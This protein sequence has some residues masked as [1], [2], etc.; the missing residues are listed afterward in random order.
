MENKNFPGSF[1]CKRCNKNKDNFF[2]Q[3]KKVTFKRKN[4]NNRK[5]FKPRKGM[6][7]ARRKEAA[8]DKVDKFYLL[9]LLLLFFVCLFFV[10]LFFLFFFCSLTIFDMENSSVTKLKPRHQVRIIKIM[11]NFQYKLEKKLVIKR[12]AHI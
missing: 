12:A 11:I 9:L 2:S 7:V 8:I 6:N 4:M 3:K 5:N 1:R 10:S